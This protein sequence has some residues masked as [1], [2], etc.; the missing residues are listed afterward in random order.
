MKQLF[1]RKGI[2]AISHGCHACRLTS[3]ASPGISFLL[4][5]IFLPR[6]FVRA[7]LSLVW[8]MTKIWKGTLGCSRELEIFCDPLEN[9]EI[10][11]C[12]N[13]SSSKNPFKSHEISF[14]L[15]GT[16]WYC[17]FFACTVSC[18]IIL[19]CLQCS[20]MHDAHLLQLD[21]TPWKCSII[22]CGIVCWGSYIITKS[23]LK[24]LKL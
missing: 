6:A 15:W 2:A 18:G 7:I 11:F 23:T 3:N 4:Q 24:I 8:S 22:S 9:W 14:C 10:C 21:N 1:F 20:A 19:L 13:R 16:A 17:K 12:C 5:I